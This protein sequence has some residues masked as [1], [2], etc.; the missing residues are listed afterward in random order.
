MVLIF[1][2]RQLPQLSWGA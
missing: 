1:C 2:D